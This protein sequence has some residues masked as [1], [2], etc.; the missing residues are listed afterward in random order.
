MTAS[1]HRDLSWSRLCSDCYDACVGEP[2]HARWPC[3][4]SSGSTTCAD[5]ISLLTEW[6][7]LRSLLV[8]VD[9][10][11]APRLRLSV[12][13]QSKRGKY[14]RLV[15]IFMRSYYDLLFQLLHLV[16]LGLIIAAGC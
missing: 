4:F 14:I 16:S 2:V 10:Y 9:Y 8:H 12:C 6:H 3:V 5:R 15:P 13:S 11:G 7:V 1:R